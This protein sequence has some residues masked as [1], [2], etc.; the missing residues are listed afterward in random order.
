MQNKHIFP[1][2]IHYHIINQ[3]NL[4]PAS[5]HSVASQNSFP[6]QNCTNL[7]LFNCHYDN[8]HKSGLTLK[9]GPRG[10]VF[11]H[12]KPPFGS[13]ENLLFCPLLKIQCYS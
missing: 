3:H 1:L 8:F 6:S 7:N 4:K 10:G 11:K 9:P 13:H 12:V 2:L 5:S